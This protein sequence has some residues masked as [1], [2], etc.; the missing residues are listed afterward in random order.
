MA[1]IEKWKID[2]IL[3]TAKIEEVVREILATTPFRTAQG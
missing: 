1:K 2:K 3:E